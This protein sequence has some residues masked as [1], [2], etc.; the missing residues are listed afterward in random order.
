MSI[1]YN[2]NYSHEDIEVIL[3][4]IQDCIRENNYTVA[5]NENRKENLDFIREYSLTAAKQQKI[6]LQIS[7]NDFCHSLKNSKIGYEHETLFV[8][9]PQVALSNIDDEQSIVDIYT[10]FN[11]IETRGE[12]WVIV[13]SFHKSNKKIDYL[14]K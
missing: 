8:F 12:N 5:R 14:F 2:Q 7:V 6:L 3:Q 4:Q 13:I 1:H 9:C 10:K 11:V